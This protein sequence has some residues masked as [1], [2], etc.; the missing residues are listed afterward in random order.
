MVFA[1]QT[2]LQRSCEPLVPRSLSW[3]REIGRVVLGMAAFGP[4]SRNYY[5]LVDCF[6]QL[7]DLG[8]GIVICR[9]EIHM[10]HSTTL[11][12]L[13]GNVQLSD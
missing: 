5:I 9:L 12:H 7:K 3:N 1:H 6:I 10:P 11:G 13:A 2:G 4:L 8:F